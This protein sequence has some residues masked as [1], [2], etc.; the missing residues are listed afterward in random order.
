[1][2]PS[3]P[4]VQRASLGCG[5]SRCKLRYGCFKSLYSIWRASNTQRKQQ[6]HQKPKHW[7]ERMLKLIVLWFNFLNLG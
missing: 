5:T 3:F 2:V 6:Q 1:M 4:K 7:S